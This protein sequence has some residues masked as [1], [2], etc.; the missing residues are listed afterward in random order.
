MYAKMIL[1]VTNVTGTPSDN[2]SMDAIIAI[3]K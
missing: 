1:M 2:E 3:V